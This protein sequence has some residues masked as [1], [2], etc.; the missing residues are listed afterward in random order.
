MPPCRNGISILVFNLISGWPLEDKFPI[1][2][3]AYIILCLL[4]S[5]FNFDTNVHIYIV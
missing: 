3:C 4:V 5:Y 1:Y 2:A